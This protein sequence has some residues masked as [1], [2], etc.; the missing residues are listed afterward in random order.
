MSSIIRMR[1]R[2]A[3][4]HA[5]GHAEGLA[6]GECKQA[7]ESA[8]KMLSKGY[9]EKDISDVTGLFIDEIEKLK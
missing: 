5:K 6:D 2:E 7:I 4:G 8:R 9:N 3:M 1:S